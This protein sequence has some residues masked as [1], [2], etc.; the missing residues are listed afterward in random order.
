[1]PPSYHDLGIYSDL[2]D[3]ATRQTELY[4]NA[5]PGRETQERIRGL[6]GFNHLP[7]TPLAVKIERTWRSNGIY[8]ELVSW[9][10]GY[11]PRTVAYILKPAG[12]AGPFP[13]I[14]ALHD[15]GGFKYFGKEK[16]ADGPEGSP[17]EL[18][19]H[20]K[21]YGG[22]AFANN[23]AK[24]GFLV[25]IHD[26]FLWGS[27]KFPFEE[28]PQQIQELARLVAGKPT[29]AD[30]ADEIA[31]YNAAA[32]F[33]EHLVTKY[34][35]LLGTDLA[36]VVSHED[37][38]AANYLLSRPDVIPGGIGCIGLSG[39]GNRGALLQAT[40]DRIRAAVIV[41]L[42]ST[43]H[44]LLDHNVQSHTWMFFPFGWSRYGDWPDLAACRAP[45]P[46]LVQYDE[47]DDLFTLEGMRAADEKLRKHYEGVGHP[48]AYTG[49][50]YPG[51]HKFDLE[52]QGA[53]FD[54]LKDVFK[55]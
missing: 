12:A 44:G 13:G 52:M 23:L 34:A 37:R 40:H 47:D 16:I 19:E 7:E 30:L 26:V 27:R 17:M 3:E 2:V 39:G 35:N 42:M 51:P 15:H 10:V 50:F 18:A 48:E 41:G 8:G 20:R 32:G 29:Q 46:L 11:G 53:A 4:P 31:V 38:I 22:R 28:I 5:A 55:S 24:Q 45:S 14:V 21:N 1:M 6:L 33:H 49:Q 9:W 25:L 54:W 43:Y 36:G